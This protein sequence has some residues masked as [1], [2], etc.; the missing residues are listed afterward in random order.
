[1]FYGVCGG[2]GGGAVL[3]HEFGGQ[4]YFSLHCKMTF[5]TSQGGGGGDKF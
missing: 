5:R 4:K 3:N 1:M 2:R